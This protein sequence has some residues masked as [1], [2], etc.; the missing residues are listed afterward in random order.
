MNVMKKNNLFKRISAAVLALVILVAAFPLLGVNVNAA[1]TDTRVVDPSTMNGWVNFFSKNSTSTENAGGIWMDKTVLKTDADS[2]EDAFGDLDGLSV[3]DPNNN[4]LVVLSALASNKSI[5]G[6][7]HIPTDTVLV[8]DVSGSMGGDDNDAVTELVEAANEAIK[9]LQDVN[10]YNRVGVVLYSGNASTSEAATASTATVLLPVGRYTH[11]TNTFLVEVG[12]SVSLNRGVKD[13][14]GRDVTVK[15]KSVSGG[16]YIQNGIYQAMQQMLAVED[17]TIEGTGF[18][19]GTKRMPIMVLMSDGAPTVATDD[20]MGLTDRQGNEYFPNSNIGD[21]R[22]ASNLSAFA[23]QLTISYA[24]AKIEEHYD[25]AGLFYS[26]SLG[27]GEYDR[28]GNLILSDQDI[29]AQ[30]VLDPSKSTQTIKQYWESY[31]NLETNGVTING[32]RTFNQS[33]YVTEMN[34]VDGYFTADTAAELE[35]AFDEIVN[36]IIIQSLYYPTLVKENNNHLDGYIEFIDDIGDY[37]EVDSIKG[38]ELGGV[39]Y[40][41]HLLAQNFT[42]DGGIL[43]TIEKPNDMGNNMVSAVVKRLN[44]EEKYGNHDEAVKAAR[45]L[46]TMAYTH[47][48]LSYTSDTE[49]S[50]YIG[51]YADNNGNYLGF[52]DDSHTAED[53]PAGAVYY[54]KSYGM[55]GAVKSGHR[56]S[57]MMYISIQV[58]TEI[59]TGHQQIIWKIPASLV[60]VVSYNVSLNSNKI[61]TA[62][63]ISVDI[64]ESAPIRL[65]FEVGLNKKINAI[66]LDSKLTDEYKNAHKN[67]DGSYNFYTNSYDQ[68]VFDSEN[69]FPSEAINTVAFFEPSVENERFY[70]NE[71]TIVYYL[72]GNTYK[73]YKGNAAPVGTSYFRGFDVFDIIDTATGEAIATKHYEPITEISLSKAVRGEDDIWYIPKGVIHRYAENARLLKT[74]NNTDTLD[75][76]MFGSVES[77]TD[78]DL[79]DGDDSYYYVDVILGNNGRISVTP[80]TGIAIAKTVDS[81]VTDTNAEF[82]FTVSANEPATFTDGTYI[83]MKLDAHGNESYGLVEFTNGVSG[84]LKIKAD[85]KI[86]VVGIP[87]GNYTVNEVLNGQYKV[88]QIDNIPVTAG[89]SSTVVTVVANHISNVEFLNAVA[90]PGN[91]VISKEIVHPYGDEYSVPDSVE[92]EFEV[93]INDASGAPRAN[94]TYATSKDGLTAITDENGKVSFGAGNLKLKNGE[95]IMLYGIDEADTVLVREINI[96]DGFAAVQREIMETVNASTV[97]VIHFTNNYRASNVY[98]I[99]VTVTGTK[100]LEGRIWL[101]TDR[102]EFQLQRYERTTG[103]WVQVGNSKFAT[104][105]NKDFSFTDEMR[106]EVYDH[107]RTEHYRIV[108]VYDANNAAGGVTYDTNARYFNIVITDDDMDGKLEISNITPLNLATVTYDDA[109]DEWN[110]DVTVTNVYA[111]HGSSAITVNINKLVANQA[112]LDVP[113]EGFEFGLFQNGELVGNS[114][115]SAVDGKAQIKLVFTAAEAGETYKYTLKEIAGNAAGFIYTDTEYEIEVSI[116][117][118]LDGTISAVVYDATAGT[119]I[120]ANADGEYLASFINTY[121][122]ESVKITFEGTKTLSGRDLDDGEFEFELY[123]ADEN[124]ANRAFDGSVSNMNGQFGF[125]EIEFMRVGTYYYVIVEKAG[126]AGGVTYDTTE[127]RITVV[128]T[129]VDFDGKLEAVTTMTDANGATKTAIEFTN[130]YETDDV[131]VSLEGTKVLN[132]KTLLADKY[133]FNL[134]EAN[135]LFT[136]GNVIDTKKNGA[137]GNF[138]FDSITYSAVGRYYYVVKEVIGTERGVTYDTTVYNVMVYIT[139]DGLGQLGATV[140]VN[141]VEDDDIVFTNTYEAAGTTV[142]LEAMKLLSG[143]DLAAGEFEFE[144]YKADANGRKVGSA[145]QTKTNDADGKVRFDAIEFNTATEENYIIVEK[146]G[147]RGGVTYDTAEYLINVQVVDNGEGQ[148]TAKV[149]VNG[150]EDTDINF[151]NTYKAAATQVIISGVKTVSGRDLAEGEFEFELYKADA[152]G[153]KVGGVIETVRN[154]ANGDIVFTAIRYENTAEDYYV[155]VEKSGNVGGITYDSRQYLVKVEVTDDGE[156]QLQA[157]VFVNGSTSTNISFVNTYTAAATTVTLEGTKALEGRDLAAGEFEF[158]IYAANA[159]FEAQGEAIEVV[160]NA[161]DGK[162]IFSAIEFNR[163][164]QYRYVIVENDTE[165]DRVTYDTTVYNVLVNVTD[166]GEGQLVANVTVNEAGLNDNADI[167]FNNVYIPRPDDLSV[168]IG[169]KKKVENIGVTVI[170]PEGFKFVL[171][172]LAGGTPN[173]AVS[174]KDG[175][176]GF[177][178]NF[179][180][181]DIGKTYNYTVAEVNDNRSCV[182]YDDTVYNIAV[183]VSLGSDN[184]LVATVTVN[185]TATA[186][187]VVEFENIY[188]D[189]YIPSPPTGDYS[190]IALWL[191]VLFVSG[192][193]FTG[194]VYMASKTNREE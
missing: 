178:L 90:T 148:L 54:N 185:G 33:S 84:E 161:A 86:Y 3:T 40:T 78:T 166:N 194:A 131:T 127:Y 44:L 73:E 101:D 120:P 175:N 155:I 26:L 50:N 126:N 117:D 81:T 172:N 9:S 132:G 61:E 42:A 91:V 76:S 192:G 150:S 32:N 55:L 70:Y 93:F 94:K 182:T 143:R 96:P 125:S 83:T 1:T 85:E 45:E 184:K 56:E 36:Q 109:S 88:S 34:Y 116:V 136:A 154:A 47:G 4:F 24:K 180:E 7:S 5:T 124:F 11:R 176:A 35:A 68:D 8:L 107:I 31:L 77:H 58:H 122:P 21:G 16:T 15:S 146:A 12:T 141:S 121:E 168:N 29:Y 41:G 129:D 72:D 46:I 130:T 105:E 103:E 142:T 173:Q 69:Y 19:A 191:A 18:Q 60:P 113:L 149:F 95:G 80:A 25:N 138:V 110:V 186:N 38:I 157:T 82:T 153:L 108:E 28:A 171:T 133:S 37:M 147:E 6:Y 128:V 48:Q 2:I 183:T 92:F 89:I 98:P 49:Y 160:K 79:T 119:D 10:N 114:A 145:L 115:I 57:D 99:N 27:L 139:D 159:Q 106:A 51:W 66:N 137:N 187:P 164:G 190:N 156:G 177:V 64:E 102:F 104:I 22:A 20:F 140:Y 118:N 144:L 59:A 112:D 17:T 181:D 75:Y 67:P 189:P 163:A 43:G 65:L 74:A 23:T 52:W 170:G 134:Y 165:A 71:N 135:E 97:G 111:P 167:I 14:N 13:A 62:T 100:V 179:T 30:S 162:I 152:N 193:I 174:D 53:R 158:A 63:E 151:N 188:N 169:I 123:I 39:L 87:A